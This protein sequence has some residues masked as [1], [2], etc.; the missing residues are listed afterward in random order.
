MNNIPHEKCSCNYAHIKA[1]EM[2]GTIALMHYIGT[3][4]DILKR[5]VAVNSLV[6]LSLATVTTTTGQALLLYSAQVSGAEGHSS[7]YC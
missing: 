6:T 3:V 5:H 4:T 2:H 7:N 1:L